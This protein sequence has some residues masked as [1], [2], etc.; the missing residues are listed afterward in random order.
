MPEILDVS[1]LKSP[2]GVL[3]REGGK[4]VFRYQSSAEAEQFVSLTM[5]VRR[6]DYTHNRLFPLFEMHLPEGY[7]LAVIK[8]HFSKLVGTDDLG[9]LRLLAPSVRGRLSYSG[10]ISPPDNLALEDLLHAPAGESL[11]D[12]LVTRF[13]LQSPLSGVQPKVLA[14]LQDKATLRLTDYIVKTW[15]G[16]YPQLALNEYWCM[17][18]VQEAGIAVPTFYLSDDGTLFIMKRFDLT[19]DGLTLGFED[20]CV[21]QARGRDDKYEGSYEQLAKTIKTFV[22][23]HHRQQAMQQFFKMMVL[24]NRLQNGDAHLKNFGVL[25]TDVNNVWLAPAFDVVSSTAYIGKD[26]SALTLMGSRRWWPREQLLRFAVN[27]C[28]LSMSQA[29]QLYDHCLAALQCVASE[30]EAQLVDTKGDDARQLLQHL[31]ER[32]RTSM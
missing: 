25:Y 7:L 19:D 27:A 30:L 14:Q 2:A 22:S 21:L 1:V 16:D 29:N 28:D 23:P 20:M 11:F 9:L 31:L 17:R 10:V 8:R 24:N 3:F 32:M 6:S 5:P 4:T 13:A 12:E 18:A 15:G 26:M